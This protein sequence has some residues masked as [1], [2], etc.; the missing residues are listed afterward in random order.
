MIA[1]FRRVREAMPYPATTPAF[2]QL[3]IDSEQNLWIRQY[4]TDPES[5][6][7]WHIFSPTGRLSGRVELPAA[8]EPKLFEASV[9]TGAWTDADNVEHLRSY[10]VERRNW[11]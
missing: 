4:P 1:G 6:A 10:E 9:V 8:F 5:N 7:I 3:A 11:K 2:G